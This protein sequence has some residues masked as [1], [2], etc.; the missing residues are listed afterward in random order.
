MPIAGIYSPVED[1]YETPEENI[2]FRRVAAFDTDQ[3]G[4]LPDSDGE[5]V[6][7]FDTEELKRADTDTILD[8]FYDR[9]EAGHYK[10]YIHRESEVPGEIVDGSSSHAPDEFEDVDVVEPDTD[11]QN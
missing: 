8:I 4:W 2:T 7:E 6:A 10:F 3:G 5:I 1:P 11:A 9:F